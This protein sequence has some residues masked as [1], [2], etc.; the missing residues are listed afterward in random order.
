VVVNLKSAECEFSQ[1]RSLCGQFSRCEL[2]TIRVSNHSRGG[3]DTISLPPDL[4]WLA[5]LVAP[6][7][8]IIEIPE[9]NH[10]VI[11]YWFQELVVPVKPW[12]RRH[13]PPPEPRIDH[14]SPMN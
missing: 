2:E 3:R 8:K 10:F 11:G 7:S 13:L 9:A 4:Q 5:I 14:T 12:F 6:G 1:T